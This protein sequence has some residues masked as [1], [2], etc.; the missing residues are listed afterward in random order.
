MAESSSGK[1]YKVRLKGPKAHSSGLFVQLKRGPVNIKRDKNGDFW[2]GLYSGRS[3]CSHKNEWWKLEEDPVGVKLD[4]K[5]KT[6]EVLDGR[7]G[8]ELES[9][10]EVVE[11]HGTLWVGSVVKDYFAL[12]NK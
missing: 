11:H 1:V 5:G 7:G 2:V 10:S 6:L 4:G 3:T 9:V 8:Q 12:V